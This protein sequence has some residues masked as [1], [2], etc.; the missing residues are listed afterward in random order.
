MRSIIFTPRTRACFGSGVV[1]LLITTSV[2]AATF[3]QQP[4]PTA[5]VKALVIDPQ[6]K[7]AILYASAG[8]N[9]P[10]F[11]SRANNVWTSTQIENLPVYLGALA[12][13]GSGN[14][15]ALYADGSGD[16]SFVP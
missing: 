12:I 11:A 9:R 16:F 6:G 3:V 13:D 8:T 14:P 1:A 15:H 10:Q 7:P 4:L 2:S 5:A